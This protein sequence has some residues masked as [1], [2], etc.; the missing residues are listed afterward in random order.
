MRLLFDDIYILDYGLRSDTVMI[1]MGWIYFECGKYMN[2][3]F[4]LNFSEFSIIQV[5]VNLA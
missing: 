3:F 5:Q 1:G 4:F 2:F